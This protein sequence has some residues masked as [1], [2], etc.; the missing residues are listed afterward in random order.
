MRLDAAL[1]ER[2]YT[3]DIREARGWI[4]SG[5][6]RVNNKYITKAGFPVRGDEIIELKANRPYVSRGGE[7]LEPIIH[8]WE[9]PVADKVFMDIGASTGGF[10]DV[11]LQKG[12]A[13]V[14]ALDVAYGILDHK[15]RSHAGVTVI[16]KTHICDFTDADIIHRLDYL[17]CDA[18]FI[19][20]RKILA[21]L[22]TN[23]KSE[24]SILWE[25]IFLFKPQFEACTEFLN[26]GILSEEYH[27]DILR[28]FEHFLTEERV[29]KLAL[30]PSPILGRKGNREYFYHLR[31][32]RVME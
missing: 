11:L 12:A 28:D 2:E 13:H 14:Y 19:S 5:K 7:K 9:F 4:L 32:I 23:F 8:Q 30:A 1:L 20:L 24:K 6:V 21:C 17:V 22:N 25:G 29:E 10:T 26:K 15:I 18:S 16:E 27:R 3:S 31:K